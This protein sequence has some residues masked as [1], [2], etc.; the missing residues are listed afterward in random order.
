MDPRRPHVISFGEALIDLF[1]GRGTELGELMP[2]QPAPGGAPANV[3]VGLSRLGVDTGFIGLVGEDGYGRLLID[4]LSR[5]GVD[6]THFRS[7]GRAPTMLAVVDAPTAREQHFVLYHG[8]DILLRAEELEHE[9]LES[10]RVFVFGS[11]TL[12]EASGSAAISAARVAGKGGAIVLFDVNLR[13]SL[14]PDEDSSRNAIWDGIETAAVVKLNDLELEFLTGESDLAKGCAQIIG[15]GAEL[16]CVSLG[17]D[18]AYF[19]NGAARGHVPPIPVDVVETTGSGD[20]FVAGLAR[21]LARGSTDIVEALPD[22]KAPTLYSMLLFANA[23]GGLAATSLG[24]MSALP[25]LEAVEE[26]L[27][28]SAG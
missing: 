6:T 27:A 7:D 8:A 4:L 17:A 26:L 5:E 12:A 14:W 13:P 3:A 15:R 23:C 19:Y 20:A 28:Q 22:L 11:V 21:G 16:V 9:Y 18:G 1:A 10:A 24:A 2:L 25:S